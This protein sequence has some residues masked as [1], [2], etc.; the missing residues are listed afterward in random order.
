ME[1]KPITTLLFSARAFLMTSTHRGIYLRKNRKSLFFQKKKIYFE[2]HD[3]ILKESLMRRPKEALEALGINLKGD[4]HVSSSYCV[5]NRIQVDLLF[6]FLYR[7]VFAQNLGPRVL[8]QQ[9][10]P[11]NSF[12]PNCTTHPKYEHSDCTYQSADVSTKIH[13]SHFGIQSDLFNTKRRAMEADLSA[14]VESHSFHIT[15]HN[16]LHVDAST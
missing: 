12:L 2:G 5:R 8:S 3:Q 1:I 13:F 4:Y 9:E 7:H 14:Q 15:S 6:G 16:L 11:L 10:I